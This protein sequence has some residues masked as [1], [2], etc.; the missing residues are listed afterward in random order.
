MARLDRRDEE[1][2]RTELRAHVLHYCPA[3]EGDELE[4]RI[5]LLRARDY[6]AFLKGNRTDHLA[7][8]LAGDAHEIAGEFVFADVPVPR[9]EIAR[10]CC[11]NL[12]QA[13]FLVDHLQKEAG[14]A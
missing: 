9:L 12:V 14:C 10:N 7:Y 2:L 6:A 8:A 13:A 5:A 3:A 1:S 4:H 11:R